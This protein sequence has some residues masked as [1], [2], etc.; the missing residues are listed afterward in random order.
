MELAIP[1]VALGG[2]FIV[3]SQSKKNNLTS[4][5]Q[6][7]KRQTRESFMSMG[8]KPN[9]L[10]NTS[11][12][13]QNYPVENIQE[14]TDNIN[15]YSNPNTETDKYFNQNLYETKEQLGIK[16]GSNIPEVYSLSG[17]YLSSEQ[18]KHN[19]MKPFYG[20][21]M[22]GDLYHANT[23]ETILDN[24]AGSSSQTIKKIEQA[25][26][27]KPEQNV[28]FVNGMPNYS[29]FYMSRVVPGT[30]NNMVKPFETQNVGP[31]LNQ[32]YGIEGSN[33]FNSGMEARDKWL[34]KTVDELRGVLTNP[35]QE[36]SLL[37]LE[38]PANNNVKN[39]GSIGDVVKYRPDGF[40]INTPDRYLTTVGDEKAGQLLPH[41]M[42]NDSNRNQT[43]CE[44]SGA[45]SAAHKNASYNSGVSEPV[46]R[47]EMVG[48]DVSISNAQGHGPLHLFNN[49]GCYDNPNN[50][51]SINLQA[52]TFRSGFSGAIG[53]VIAPILDILRPTKKA[54]TC[55]GVTVYGVPESSVAS[56]YVI[57]INDTTKTTNKQ[58]TMY[59]S[60]GFINNQGFQQYVANQTAIN[61]QRDTTIGVDNYNKNIGNANNGQYGHEDYNSYYGATLASNKN[62]VENH[63]S[64]GS[65]NVFNN[66]INVNITKNDND[67]GSFDRNQAP[68][69]IISTG[70]SQDTYGKINMPQYYDQ[71]IGCNRIEPSILEQFRSNPYVFSLTQSA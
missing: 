63:T 7:S 14:V 53:S 17:N 41:Q 20:S 64:M 16:E 40:F 47:Q 71:C 56:N 19:N 65:T 66:K 33:G 21:K 25:P 32:G 61:N 29:E 50:S 48:H 9:Y 24:M 30:K 27:F 62:L 60:N 68:K 46:K 57:N 58:T 55:S 35:K 4:T 10:P 8:S 26:L 52:D 15:K 31:G 51:R 69:N 11:V 28:Q 18:F 38:G 3:N 23:A 34:P 54:E 59:D 1:L 37:G 45:A 49:I 2:L 39:L 44:Y 67:C 22:K 43:T 13:A 42:V 6:K 36:F 5:H 70:P 12:I